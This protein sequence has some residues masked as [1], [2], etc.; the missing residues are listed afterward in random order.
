MNVPASIALVVSSGKAS[1]REL[2]EFYGFEDLCD[3]IEIIRID[4]HN[5][6][7]ANKVDD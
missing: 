3:L 4:A 7:L 1:L 2:Q 6:W 5:Q